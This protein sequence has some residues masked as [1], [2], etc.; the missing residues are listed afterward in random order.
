LPAH[1]ASN[2]DEAGAFA[3]FDFLAFLMGEGDTIQPFEGF[4]L[5]DDA[6][7]KLAKLGRLVTASG[8]MAAL[9]ATADNDA[10]WDA[11]IGGCSRRVAGAAKDCSFLPFNL[12]VMS[13]FGKSL[14]LTAPPMVKRE[15]VCEW[16][17]ET[18][19]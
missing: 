14:S 10:T 18:F 7:Q 15:G 11:R 16:W 1:S 12:V 19:V 9:A 5:G 8:S 17:I 2:D 13:E 4:F 6:A 3:L